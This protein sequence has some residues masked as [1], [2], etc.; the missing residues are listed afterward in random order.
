MNNNP[1]FPKIIDNKVIRNNVN[2]YGKEYINKYNEN[3]MNNNMWGNINDNNIELSFM[4]FNH[5]QE[6]FGIENFFRKPIKPGNNKLN[7]IFN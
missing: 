7:N 2:F 1:F 6:S 5:K 3:I 4:P